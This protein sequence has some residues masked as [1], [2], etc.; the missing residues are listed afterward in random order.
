[1]RAVHAVVL[2]GAGCLPVRS[3]FLDRPWPSDEP[4]VVIAVD[5]GV[6]LVE[7]VPPGLR[8]HLPVGD[9]AA[10]IFARTYAA[11]SDGRDL[12]SC[13]V[14]AGGVRGEALGP[15]TGAWRSAELGTYDGTV[16]LEVEPVPEPFDL[17][18]DGC[19]KPPRSCELVVTLLSVG[20]ASS[21]LEGAAAISDD[22]VLFAGGPRSA[23]DPRDLFL[24]LS[25]AG[26]RT[27]DEL[28]IVGPIAD[29]DLRGDLVIGAAGN[30]VFT[31]DREGRLVKT[32]TIAFSTVH[33]DTGFDLTT[34][35]LGR[36]G[37]LA[38]FPANVTEPQA[39]VT[40]DYAAVP[41]DQLPRIA[42]AFADRMLLIGPD[43]RLYRYDGSAWHRELPE[44]EGF[45]AVAIDDRTMFAI[46]DQ[47]DPFV[48]DGSA[49]RIAGDKIHND[50]LKGTAAIGD[51]RFLIVGQ[52]GRIAFW[53]GDRY[54]DLGSVARENLS[55]VDI[56]PSRRVAFIAGGIEDGPGPAAVRLDIP[57]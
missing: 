48:H 9:G 2:L 54:C 10:R 50:I 47:D 17:R 1:M 26:V 43:E 19:A 6:E 16:A 25:P 42:V 55:D 20:P 52:T 53:S 23:Q 4:A 14:L 38:M 51:G 37:E 30:R 57:E 33:L 22:T 11:L 12:A 27:F 29:L 41:L 24:E 39:I 34:V 35:A 46:S 15:P 44:V 49:W 31:L 36:A 56:A 13:E 21:A 3:L 18:V 5:G 45:A 8:Y 32:A 28:S 40:P 7:I